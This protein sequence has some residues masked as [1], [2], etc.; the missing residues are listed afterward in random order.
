MAE[1]ADYQFQSGK[2]YQQKMGS[3]YISPKGIVRERGMDIAEA[4]LLTTP[5]LIMAVALDYEVNGVDLSYWNMDS[6]DNPS[7]MDQAKAAGAMFCYI[8]AGYGNNTYDPY[9]NYYINECKRLN[10]PW[11]LY[12]FTKIGKDWQKHI[13]FFYEAYNDVGGPL[14]PVLDCEW[15]EL[16]KT[17]TNSWIYKA[18]DRFKTKAGWNWSD[19]TP[20]PI[21]YTS[22]GWW[23]AHVERNDWAKHLELWDA[24]W[25]TAANP[26][27]PGDWGAITNPKTWLFWQWSADGNMLGDD[28]GMT[29]DA[30]I[31]LNRFNGTKAEFEARFNVELDD[32]TPPPP[33]PEPEPD[34]EPPEAVDIYTWAINV[35]DWLR[36]EHGY[37]GPTV[38]D[39]E[40]PFYYVQVKPDI[41]LR[42]RDIPD[43]TGNIID[44]LSAG[45]TVTVYPP[46]IQNDGYL[47]GRIEG[48]T[49]NRWIALEFTILLG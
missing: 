37:T 26:I 29:G 24:H 41:T 25:T 22:P 17:L 40:A 11:G 33:D 2:A 3:G 10:I 47:W 15:T 39:E 6:L 43:T 9:A 45:T 7:D 20:Y 4:S 46:E 38:S 44:R 48:P 31:D 28:Y 35:D 12:W 42:V 8:R 32:P 16:N 18:A 21:I 14:P 23:D 30:D 34:P 27:L 19:N 49:E 36:L 1:I 5:G 13:D